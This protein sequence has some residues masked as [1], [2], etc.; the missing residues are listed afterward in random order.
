M[1]QF[2][3]PFEE[4]NHYAETTYS[5]EA[6]IQFQQEEIYARNNPE[7]L[8]EL[9]PLATGMQARGVVRKRESNDDESDTV[10]SATKKRYN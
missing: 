5:S 10:T 2:Y 3:D 4:Y 9:K 8:P 6:F 7:K 1:S